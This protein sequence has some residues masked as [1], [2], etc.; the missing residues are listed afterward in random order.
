MTTTTTG[1]DLADIQAQF[2]GFDRHWPVGRY[3]YCRYE[4]PAAG[5]RLLQRLLPL[6]D[7]RHRKAEHHP[8]AVNAAFT[9]A[10]LRALELDPTVLATF[11]PEFQ[12][13]MRKRAHLNGDV[14]V[15]APEHWDPIWRAAPIHLWIGVYARSEAALADWDRAF[16]DWAAQEPGVKLLDTQ[17]VARFYADPDRPMHID[18]PASNPRKPVVLEHFGFR[19]GVSNPPVAGMPDMEVEGAGRRAEDGSW[20]PLATGEFLLGHVDADGE[21]PNAPEPEWLAL[22]GSFMVLRKLEQDVDLFRE[23]VAAQAARA[24]VGADDLAARMFGR[25]RDGTPL[26]DSSTL[27][28]FDYA[29]DPQGRRCPLGAHMRRANPRGSMGFGT[30]LV[31]RHRVLRN[32]ITYGKPVARGQRQR[33]VNG[34]AGQ[35]LMFVCFNASFSRQYEFVVQQWINYGNDQ[36]QGNDRDPIVGLQLDRG[37]LLVPGDGSRPPVVCADLKQFVRNRG[38]DYFFLPGITAFAALARH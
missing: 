16:R 28:D 1:L 23:Y 37:R 13:G 30:V 35:G 18:D 22:N 20:Q 26:P 15:N 25:R 38:G 11:P 17:D 9:H 14:G 33:E 10:G 29:D 21:I 6:A 24:G 4:S 36:D 19:D 3:S 8:V 32:G 5:R 34:E 12:Q 31:D 2:G 27:N 7:C